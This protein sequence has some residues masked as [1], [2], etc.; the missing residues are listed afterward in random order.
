MEHRDIGL[1]KVSPKLAALQDI[2][3]KKTKDEVDL[4]W[5]LISLF[6]FERF[7][8]ED[9]IRIYKEVGRD[10]FVRLV[11]TVGGKEIKFPTRE[12]LFDNLVASLLYIDRELRKMSWSDIKKKYPTI[13][14]KSIKYAI[15]IKNLDAFTETQVAQLVKDSSILMEELDGK[16]V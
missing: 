2:I 14:V 10:T 16:K 8:T 4:L 11:Q 3:N 15:K 5:E 1:G 6:M 13:D 12:E 9:M 7:K